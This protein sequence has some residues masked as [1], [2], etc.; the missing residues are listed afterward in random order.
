MR[1]R[2]NYVKLSL[3]MHKISRMGEIKSLLSE[4]VH[5]FIH[6]MH[7]TR[8]LKYRYNYIKISK[9]IKNLCKVLNFIR[10]KNKYVTLIYKITNFSLLFCIPHI[11]L[12][13]ELFYDDF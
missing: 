12:T 4:K 7:F 6:V 5:F 2:G 8:C 11:L 1:E 13:N 9:R 3:L 10:N